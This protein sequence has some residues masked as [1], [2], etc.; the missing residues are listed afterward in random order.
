MNLTIVG[1]WGAY[2]EKN[3][4]TSS[5]LLEEKGFH[6]LIDCGSGCLS[7]LQN[8]ISLKQ[9]DAVILSHYHHDHV[10]DVGPLQYAMLIQ[11][12]LGADNLPLPIYAPEH[13]AIRFQ[14]LTYRQVTIG[15]P[16][17]GGEDM[18]IGP[19]KVSFLQTVH[20]VYCLAMKFQTQSKTFVYTADTSWSDGLVSFAKGA[21]LLLCEASLY[22]DDQA[23]ESGHMTPAMAGRL[24][25][26][27]GVSLLVLTH[28]P[29]FGDHR[30][31]LEMAQTQFDGKVV[32]AQSGLTFKI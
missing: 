21:D 31:L 18:T 3:E 26:E 25:K 2:P 11:G 6:L 17:K 22:D 28:F 19:W 9:L 8:F 20:P 10:A 32:L 14:S 16:I 7:Q 1:C 24:A 13:D 5:Y 12:Y 30:Q 23:K 27:A 4:A 29:H 15:R